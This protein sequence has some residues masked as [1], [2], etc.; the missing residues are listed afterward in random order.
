LDGASLTIVLTDVLTDILTGGSPALGCDASPDPMLFDSFAAGAGQQRLLTLGGVFTPDEVLAGQALFADTLTR[1]LW[2]PVEAIGGASV[3][4]QVTPALVAKMFPATSRAN[5]EL[6]LPLI[7]R[8]LMER[9]LVD[10][11][12]VLMTLATVRAETSAFDPISESPSPLN[13]QS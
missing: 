7:R 1:S 11:G 3:I 12:M 9:G 10:K 4:S 6:Y 13:T 8:A 2:R 5:I